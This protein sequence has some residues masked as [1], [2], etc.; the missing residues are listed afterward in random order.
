MAYTY[1]KPFD[2]VP[3]R[4]NRRWVGTPEPSGVIARLWD[5]NDDFLKV[6]VG[7]ASSISGTYSLVALARRQSTGASYLIA[8]HHSSN[9]GKETL[10]INS[11]GSIGLSVDFAS[12][13]SGALTVD[14][15]DG[16][17]IVGVSKTSGS[18][19]PRFHVYKGGTWS[20]GDGTGAIG[21]SVVPLDGSIH[22]GQVF[23]GAIKSQME[24]AVAAEFDTALSDGDF[25]TLE[26]G[27]QTQDWFDLSPATLWDFNQASTSTPVEDLMGGGADE[28][29]ITGTTVISDGPPAWTYGVTSVQTVEL[30]QPEE[31]DTAQTHTVHKTVT[32]G[33]NSETDTAQTHTSHKIKTI[34][35][36]EETDTVQSITAVK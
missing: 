13:T 3:G 36:N 19:V 20:H 31:T 11:D 26:D 8:N 33:L 27:W 12:T 28:I 25:E 14:R 35:Q 34:G 22:F 5:G 16:W 9:A 24:L 1:R 21:N 7:N 30:T 10:T 15:T 23:N 6:S 32:L 4:Q 17:V 2:F 29:S 18:T